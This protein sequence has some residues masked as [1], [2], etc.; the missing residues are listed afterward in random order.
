[1]YTIYAPPHHQDGLIN[2]TKKD[3]EEHDVEFDG[4]TTE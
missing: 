4:K 1:M 2:V 3:A